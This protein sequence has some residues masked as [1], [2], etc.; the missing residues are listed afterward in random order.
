MSLT[1]NQE[2]IYMYLHL[3]YIPHPWTAYNEISKLN[4]GSYLVIDLDTQKVSKHFYWNIPA[5]K[6]VS[7]VEIQKSEVHELLI[8]SIDKRMIADVP[9]GAFL[10]GGVDSSLICS[11]S[12]K[13]LGK[14]LQTFSISYGNEYEFFNELEYSRRIA[15]KY[16]HDHYNLEIDIENLFGSFEDIMTYLEEPNANPSAFLNHYLC[17][18]AREKVAVSLSGLGGDELFGGYNRYRALGKAV[19]LGKLP[20]VLTSILKASIS[21]IPKGRMNILSNLGRASEKILRSVHKNPETAYN[22]LIGYSDVGSKA[23]I[24]SQDWS[25]MYNAAM[26]LDV[27]YYMVDD[28]LELT[29]KMSMTHALEV[30]VPMLDYRLVEKAFEIRGV[31]KMNAKI[32]KKIL[33]EIGGSYIDKDI[34][35]RRKMGFSIPLEAWMRKLGKKQILNRLDSNRF[36]EIVN[37]ENTLEIV[38][39][40]FEKKVDLSNQIYSY[41]VLDQWMCNNTEVRI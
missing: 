3:M 34:L 26:R 10:S 39:R 19:M 38:N 21:F 11:I 36:Y 2:A 6:M 16:G 32:S 5:K 15:K 37:K 25:D 31:D 40:F 4:P 22:N 7:E 1:I 41:L 27:K 8:D 17:G 24:L 14:S 33:K 13:D 29:D 35:Y 28:L 9:V 20:N 30:R 18:F 23:L 12:A